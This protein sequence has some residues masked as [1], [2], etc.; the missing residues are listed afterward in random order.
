VL[1]GQELDVGEVVRRVLADIEDELRAAG[2]R[3]KGRRPGSIRPSYT[4]CSP[5]SSPISSERGESTPRAGSGSRSASR[6][7]GSSGCSRSATGAKGSPTRTKQGVF[8]RFERLGK[9]GVK[10]TGLGLAIARRIV[11]LHRGRIWIEDNPRRER[12]PVSV[13]KAIGEVGETGARAGV[14]AA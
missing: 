12:L 7:V 14:G 11:E 6:A 10:G 9:E 1:T 2:S 8:T 4:R 13:H 3:S 5:T